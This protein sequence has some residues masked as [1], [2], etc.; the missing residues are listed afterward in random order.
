LEI[1]SGFDLPFG[2]FQRKTLSLS[3]EEGFYCSSWCG[4]RASLQSVLTAEAQRKEELALSVDDL[5]N[6][7]TWLEVAGDGARRR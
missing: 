5:A 4:G 3:A 1:I 2:S 7:T 6:K